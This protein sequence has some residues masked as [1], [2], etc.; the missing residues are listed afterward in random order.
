MGPERKTE[1]E[2]SRRAALQA[3][4]DAIH[5]ANR[6]YWGQDATARTTTEIAEYQRRL[7]RLEEIR[8]EL[9]ELEN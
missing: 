8:K 7:E 6:V 5:H 1:H 2:D 3:E 9:A 4:M